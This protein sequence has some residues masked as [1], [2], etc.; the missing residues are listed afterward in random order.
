M[1][2][3]PSFFDMPPGM[4]TL[5]HAMGDTWQQAQSMPYRHVLHQVL[6]SV[7]LS[8]TNSG[9]RPLVEMYEFYEERTMVYLQRIATDTREMACDNRHM[10]IEKRSKT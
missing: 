1:G 3:I 8:V 4:V 9:R 2:R 6:R 10:Q 5:Y 7:C